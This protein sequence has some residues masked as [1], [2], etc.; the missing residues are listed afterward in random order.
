MQGRSCHGLAL[1]C[2]ASVS[3]SGRRERD[4]G[5]VLLWQRLRAVGDRSQNC[6]WI[7]RKMLGDKKFQLY[8]ISALSNSAE[9]DFSSASKSSKT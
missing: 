7:C 9:M 8:Q 5:R 4:P 3:L 1:P 6:L 2:C